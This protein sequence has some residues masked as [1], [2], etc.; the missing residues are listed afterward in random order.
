MS[1]RTDGNRIVNFTGD[2]SLAA[3]IVPVRITR[4]FQNSLLGELQNEH[5]GGIH[6]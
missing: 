4:A 6:A 3:R 2:S 1:G 5:G